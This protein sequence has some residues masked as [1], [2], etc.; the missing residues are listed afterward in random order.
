MSTVKMMEVKDS[1]SSETPYKL[2]D[3]AIDGVSSFGGLEA[4]IRR[5]QISSAA[6]AGLNLNEK[7]K[8]PNARYSA[9][10]FFRSVEVYQQLRR[11]RILSVVLTIKDTED[12]ICAMF[13]HSST[14]N[15]SVKDMDVLVQGT[16]EVWKAFA[17]QLHKKE[18][19]GLF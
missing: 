12:N 18:S 1:L 19:K 2:E 3:I 11:N 14:S 7:E 10:V 5:M 8:A 16:R 6:M 4:Q 13:Y 17:K 9:D 15:A